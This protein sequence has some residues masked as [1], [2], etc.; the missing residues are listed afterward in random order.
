MVPSPCAYCGSNEAGTVDHVV[1]RAL[2]PPSKATSKV[3]R[4]TVPACRACN[5]SWTDDE[6]HFRNMM[7]VA[8]EANPAVRALW[9]GKARRSFGHSDG[10]RRVRDLAARL[11][12]VETPEGERHK[13][14]PGEDPRVTRIV[15]KVIRGLCHHHR[16]V[17][18]VSD[19]QVWVDI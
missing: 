17:S 16:L 2:Y 3:Q 13:V 1:P 4:I 7:L 12:V 15:R 10:H 11:V 18:A 14:Y 9:E 6:P 5:G 8:G 19:G